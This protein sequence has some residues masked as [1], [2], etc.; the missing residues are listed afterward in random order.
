M[1][2]T[3]GGLHSWNKKQQGVWGRCF[4]SDHEYWNV[5]GEARNIEY[6]MLI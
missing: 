2:D 1:M 3:G 4:A 6:D 5:N